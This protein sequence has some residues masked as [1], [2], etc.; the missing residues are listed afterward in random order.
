MIEQP[1]AAEW[2]GAAIILGGLG[3][4]LW[5]LIDD[6]WDLV[7]VRRFGEIGGPRWVSGMEHL[8]SDLAFLGAWCCVF[9]VLTIAVYLPS[10]ADPVADA[11]AQIAGWLRFASALFF[12][13]AQI[14]RRVGRQKLRALPLSAWEQML[15]SMMDGLSPVEREAMA[16]RLL[17]AT[18]AGRE[19]GHLVANRAQLPVSVLERLA[20]N[21]AVSESL[22]SDAALALAELDEMVTRSKQL[23]A[24]IKAQE[25]AP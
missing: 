22:R 4:S 5:G 6:L 15:A 19:L 10:R 7:N 24:S 20:G 1:T 12:L 2:L 18:T 8:L 25:G 13:A 17:R 3:L 21:P 11:L 16:Q 23:H 9:G 14:N